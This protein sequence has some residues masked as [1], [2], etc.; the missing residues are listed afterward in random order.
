MVFLT[1]YKG[2]WLVMVPIYLF[3]TGLMNC[4]YPLEESISMDFVPK[5]QRS[6]WKSL[7]S[8]AQFGWCG[9]AA[10][11][12]YLVDRYNYSYTFLITAFIQGTSLLFWSM[13]IPLVPRKEHSSSVEKGCDRDKEGGSQATNTS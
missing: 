7:E 12:G 3:R 5:E 1:K 8:I 13:L 9:S 6:R 10:L 4:T 11:G 2:Q